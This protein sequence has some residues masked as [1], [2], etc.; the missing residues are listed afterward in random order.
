M[1]PTETPPLPPEI[2]RFRT[3]LEAYYRA[4]PDLI[5]AGENDRWIIV[6]GQELSETWDTHRDARQFGLTRFSDGE[7]LVQRIDIRFR[8]LLAR[9][10][11][12]NR[13]RES[14]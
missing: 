5:A 9:Y 8:E 4:L 13:I 14:A 10:F 6:K 1:S 3:E 12:S 7:F 11:E 2:E